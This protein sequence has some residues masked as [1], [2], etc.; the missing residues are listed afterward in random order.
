MAKQTFT[1][2]SPSGEKYETSSRTE[3]TNLVM[4]H[5][6]KETSAKTSPKSSK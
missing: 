5:G 3:K 1:L 2:E 6:Y 4:G